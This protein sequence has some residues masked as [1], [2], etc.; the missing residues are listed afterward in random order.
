M[1]AMTGDLA[2]YRARRRHT[3]RLWVP[4]L[5]LLVLLSPI[6]LL[7]A[8]MGAIVLQAKGLPPGRTLYGIGRVLL[9]L[10]GTRIQVEAPA[11]SV[12]IIIS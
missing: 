6:L 5:L 9:A 11:A 1:N 4:L 8:L 7:L 2:P 10:P 3:I 12:H